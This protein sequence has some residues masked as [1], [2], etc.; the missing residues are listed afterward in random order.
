[1]TRTFWLSL[2]AGTAAILAADTPGP[3]EKNLVPNGD[4]TAGM[5]PWEFRPGDESMIT[6]GPVEGADGNA[7]E[8]H[9]EGKVLGINS[10][11]LVI[12]R[13]LDPNQ[14]YRVKARIKSAGIDE[15]IFAFSICCYDKSG[16]RIRQMSVHHLN[17]H[18]KPHDWIEKKCDMGAGTARAFP[19]DTASVRLR[20]SFWDRAG[21]C[22]GRI[23]V[24][25]ASVTKHDLGPFAAWPASILIDCGPIETRFESRSFWTLYRLDYK[26]KRVGKDVFGSHWGSVANFRGIGFIGSGHTENDEEQVLDLKLEIDGKSI[27]K[28]APKYTCEHA[29]LRK[30]SHIRDL[31]LTTR[32]D[33]LED[34]IV[35]DVVLRAKKETP[36]NLMYHFMHPWVPEMS[37]YCGVTEEGIEVRGRFVGDG[38]M[39]IQQPVRWS[40]VYSETL[41]RGAVTVVLAVPEGIEWD[42]RYW[43]K[44]GVYRKH[45]FATLFSQSPPLNKDLHYRVAVLPFEATPE[46]WEQVAYEKADIGLKMKTAP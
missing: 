34:R 22:R 5:K 20:F 15:G 42:A 25:D 36:L 1:M 7:L 37:D 44:E 40:A 3:S 11:P 2:L 17:T 9:P 19:P 21:N 46:T 13:D 4:F 39:K 6:L 31:Y 35:E 32:V 30:K 23:W 45:Y 28:P 8:L 24:D 43:D 29:T 33:V 38:K 27:D 14:C 18:S 10:A 41:E 16:K 12:G 26:G